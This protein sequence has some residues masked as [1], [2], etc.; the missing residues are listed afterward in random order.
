MD[1]SAGPAYGGIQQGFLKR[2][3]NMNRKLMISAKVIAF[4]GLMMQLEGCIFVA[5]EHRGHWGHRGE[6]YEHAESTAQLDIKI[7]N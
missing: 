2:K 5:P 7:R 1:V 3:I 6:H 4:L